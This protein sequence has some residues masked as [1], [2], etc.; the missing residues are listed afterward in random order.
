MMKEG[1]SSET[2]NL[3]VSVKGSGCAGLSYAM[4]FDDRI[5]DQTDEVIECD[6]LKIVCDKKS[7]LYLWEQNWNILMD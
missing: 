6:G 2:H 7:L 5:D 4:D 1:I 3:R